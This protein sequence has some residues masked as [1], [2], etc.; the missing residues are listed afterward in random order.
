[1]PRLSELHLSPSNFSRQIRLLSPCGCVAFHLRILLPCVAPGVWLPRDTRLH[2]LDPF[3]TSL[4]SSRF[5][6]SHCAFILQLWEARLDWTTTLI[7][8]TPAAN[9]DPAV[10]KPRV[11]G[12]VRRLLFCSEGPCR[13]TCYL[14]WFAPLST[15]SEPVFKPVPRGG[16]ST[17]VA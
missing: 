16:W 4:F 15:A 14:A 12:V 1:M 13:P 5:V 3:P 7:A 11:G 9:F 6:S 8:V 17:F 10:L 2:N